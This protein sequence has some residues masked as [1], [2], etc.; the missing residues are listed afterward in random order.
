MQLSDWLFDRA[1]KSHAIALQSLAEMFFDFLTRVRGIDTK[2]VAETIWRDYQ[3][4]GRSDRPGFLAPY[5][6]PADT[7]VRRAGK[8]LPSRQARHLVSETQSR[9]A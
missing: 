7:R 2:E 5:V 6:A 9:R 4:G 3:R 8:N 1:G